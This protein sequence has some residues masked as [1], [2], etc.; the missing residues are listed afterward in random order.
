MGEADRNMGKR[1]WKGNQMRV[2]AVGVMAL[3]MRGT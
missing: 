3:T 2:A 1:N